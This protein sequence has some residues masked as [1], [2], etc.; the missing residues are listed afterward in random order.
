MKTFTINNHGKESGKKLQQKKRFK[1]N[2]KRTR[3]IMTRKLAQKI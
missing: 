3:V 2:Q 1:T